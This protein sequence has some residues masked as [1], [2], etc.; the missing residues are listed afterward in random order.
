MLFLPLFILAEFYLTGRFIELLAGEKERRRV[1]QDIFKNA[2]TACLKG[3]LACFFLWEL[4]YT[5]GS[6]TKLSLGTISRIFAVMLAIITLASVFLSYRKRE[7]KIWL[8][9]SEFSN[10]FIPAIIL[11][12]IQIIFVTMNGAVLTGSDFTD[13]SSY[14]LKSFYDGRSLP[15]L[16]YHDGYSAFVAFLALMTDLGVQEILGIVMPPVM[17]T[18]EYMVC[19]LWVCLISDGNPRVRGLVMQL[20]FIA[21]VSGALAGRG[22]F[23]DLLFKG[24]EPENLIFAVLVP[25]LIFGFCDVPKGK[26]ILSGIYGVFFLVAGFFAS[27]KSGLAIMVFQMICCLLVTGGRRIKKLFSGRGQS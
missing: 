13:S 26:L 7:G 2:G 9:D 12:F 18:L 21:N 15:A 11:F 6:F 17:I 10:T 8:S 23:Y 5:A 4:L 24:Y 25:L 3:M 16:K 1:K 20:P 14:I 22:L 19:I 27:G